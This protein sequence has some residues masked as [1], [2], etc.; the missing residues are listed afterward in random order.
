MKITL[1]QWRRIN[2]AIKTA[3]A[4]LK[5]ADDII[6]ETAFD[7]HDQENHPEVALLLNLSRMLNENGPGG[8]GYMT[9]PQSEWLGGTTEGPNP[10]ARYGLRE[11][12]IV[13]MGKRFSAEEVE[14]DRNRKVE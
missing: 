12:N 4:A 13:N 7:Q 10:T 11:P 2:E 3:E 5:A 9:H 1:S 8:W 6:L 14:A